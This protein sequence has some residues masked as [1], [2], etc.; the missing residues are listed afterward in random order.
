MN[1]SIHGWS[2]PH[3]QSQALATWSP[4]QSVYGGALPYHTAGRPIPT[5]IE[6]CVSYTFVFLGT[7]IL[8]SVLIG[9]DSRTH[10]HITSEDGAS[11]RTV[12]DDAG[13]RR[14]ALITWAEQPTIAIDGL[15]WT[16][17]TSQWLYLASNR[18]CRTMISGGE[19]FSWRPSGRFLELFSLA[20]SD[21]DCP[22]LARISHGPSG[23]T[24]QLSIGAVQKRL[25][26]AA[27]ISAV[28]LM[29]GRKID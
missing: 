17:R 23:V 16:M 13:G 15:G 8:N 29:S 18:T 10:F 20:N 6:F 24:L 4:R 25:L 11:G 7:T 9:T 2:S 12:M 26:K 1:P 5:P 22:A 3:L 14:V 27:V 28:L 19:T 21:S